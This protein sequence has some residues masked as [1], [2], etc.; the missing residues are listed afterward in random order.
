L[1]DDSTSNLHA[2]L[3]EVFE[4]SQFKTPIIPKF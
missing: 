4:I 2:I 3:K 1:Y